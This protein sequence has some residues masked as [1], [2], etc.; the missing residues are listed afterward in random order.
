MAVGVVGT[1]RTRALVRGRRPWRLRR[2][3]GAAMAAGRG[4]VGEKKGLGK[5]GMG[6]RMAVRKGGWQV[7]PSG[8]GERE[9]ERAGHG[10]F[11]LSQFGPKTIH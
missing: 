10:G 2:L 8:E 1:T 4:V 5:K 6:A 9:R 11:G 3:G 7:G